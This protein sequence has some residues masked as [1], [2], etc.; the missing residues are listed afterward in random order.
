MYIG[1]RKT[2]WI[3]CILL[4]IQCLVIAAWGTQKERMHVDEMFTLE[5]AK[6]NGMSMRYWDLAE[7]FYGAEHTREEFMERI[8]VNRDDL[9]VGKGAAQVADSLLNGEVYYVLI[10]IFSSVYPDHIPWIICVGFNLVCFLITQIVLYLIAKDEFGDICALFT[11]TVYGFSAGAISTVLYARCYMMVAMYAVLLIYVFHRFVKAGKAWQKIVCIISS[12]V[13]A[14]CAYRTHQFGLILFIL[15]AGMAVLYMLVKKKWNALVWLGVGYG[16]PCL[17]GYRIIWGKI[18]G[19]F[20]GGV[21]PTFYGNLRNTPGSSRIYY[22]IKLLRMVADHMFGNIWIMLV[23]IAAII[24]YLIRVKIWRKDSALK[25]KMAACGL[26]M[27]A[28]I[29][30]LVM[31]FGGAIEWRYFSPA[32]PI[33]ALLVGVAASLFYTDDRISIGARRTLLAMMICIPLISYG[34]HHVSEMYAG[35]EA[36]RE[37]L[38]TK[39]HGVNGIMV[40]HDFQGIGENWLYEAATLWPQESNVL[41]IQNKM[42]YEDELCYN[43]TDSKILLWLTVDY[44]NEEAI[45]RF[46][47]LTDY[48]D[49]ELVMSTYSLRIYECNK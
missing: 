47:E 26:V 6:Q 35:Q 24:I 13:L 11:T 7:D 19:F 36:C 18:R 46:R 23:V 1:K 34:S 41:I 14:F 21:A 27:I 33:I 17:L 10:N 3:F 48:T 20:T 9:I 31:L 22:M 32:Y 29:Y 5:G 40:H 25:N 42:L 2:F 37:E 8:T 43:R 30:Y 16:V 12:A 44:N 39:Y 38:E 28:I 49:I 4:L 45:S 15:I